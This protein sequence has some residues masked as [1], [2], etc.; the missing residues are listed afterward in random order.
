M[1]RSIGYSICIAAFIA[2]PA[3]AQ[4]SG[5]KALD[6]WLKSD[7]R[8]GISAT[9]DTAHESGDT[10]TVRGLKYTYSKTF[11]FEGGSDSGDA[12]TDDKNSFSVDISFSVPEMV[13]D[14]L[15]ADD[16]GFAVKSL[17]LSDGSRFSAQIKGDDDDEG[18]ALEGTMD[19]YSVTNASWAQF[20]M[21]EDDPNRPCRSLSP[22]PGDDRQALCGRTEGRSVGTLFA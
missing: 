11:E 22:D 8:L 20:P 10:L 15:T 12:D 16:V 2:T 14:S 7:A 19:G 5:R 9:Y 21:I 13:A 1:K 4:E 18:I 17:T 3:T 6:A